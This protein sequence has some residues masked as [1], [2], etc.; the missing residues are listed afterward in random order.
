M[1]IQSREAIDSIYTPETVKLCL[2]A[3]WG[4]ISYRL[5]T[6]ETI[7]YWHWNPKGQ[8]TDEANQRGYFVGSSEL[9]NPIRDSFGYSLPHRGCTHNGGTEGGYSR[10]TDGDPNTFWKSNPYLTQAFTHDDDALH[11]QWIIVD[12][13]EYYDVNAIRID[14]CEP[15]ALDYQVE[16]WVGADPMNWEEPAMDATGQGGEFLPV[17]NQAMGKWVRFHNGVVRDGKGGSVTLKLS[18]DLVTTRWVRV[19]MTRSSNH[20]GPH[21]ADDLRHRVGYAIYEVYL[22]RLEADGK[23]ADL[24]THV[25]D[26]RRQ[27]ATYCSSTDPWHTVQDLNPHGDQTGWDIFYTSGITNGLPAL[28]TVPLIYSV[29]EDAAA[30]IA[31]LKKRG[32]PISWVEMDEEADG[33]YYMPEDYASLYIQFADA[34]HKVD[35]TLKL[36][37]PVYQGI[38]QDVSVWPN[39]RGDKSWFRRFYDY[40]KARNREGDLTFASFEI[41]PF[42]ACA[43][44]W[45]DLYRN[46][47]LTRKTLQSFRDDGLPSSVPLMNTESNLSGSLS[48][49]MSDIFSALWLADNVGSFFAEG[50]ALYIHSP[51]EPSSI[52]HGCQGFAI[53]GNILT[54][55]AGKI[56]NYMAFYHA[57]RMIN[58]E[59]VTHRTGMHHLY[60]VDVGI[61]DTAGNDLVTSYAVRR[62]DGNWALLLINKDRDNTHS[63]RIAFANGGV[64]GHFSGAI[65]VIT[66]GSEQYVWHGADVTAH[67][68]PE[69]PPVVSAVDASAQT[70]FTLPKASVTVLRGKVAGLK[71]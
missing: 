17:F 56:I 16:Y 10:L 55:R 57:G 51:I 68:D 3:G 23:F 63:L 20:P 58:E 43:T 9:G 35:P 8:W 26:G 19:V 11:P 33:Q 59:W 65:R 1:D 12:L 64:T 66:F 69:L 39:A 70:V 54:D 45:D 6:P 2:S 31:Y 30:M 24:V 4:P 28:I 38:N 27:T 29:P 22:G 34:I 44:K 15:C 67:A 7:D 53:W 52:E 21:G 18:N 60:T 25:A 36:G 49:Y 40:L 37:G 42:E 5:H 50:G 13:G 71:S 62:P 46:R 14:W 32:Y 47:E 48:V 41:Y 61:Q